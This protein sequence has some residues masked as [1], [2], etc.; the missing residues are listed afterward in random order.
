MI[1]RLKRQGT[2]VKIVDPDLRPLADRLRAAVEAGLVEGI[3]AKP[4][5]ASWLRN[6]DPT[7]KA[8]SDAGGA[9]LILE[10]PTPPQARRLPS[11]LILVPVKNPE[12]KDRSLIGAACDALLRQFNK[13]GENNA[14]VCDFTR[15]W[16]EQS[17]SCTA[18]GETTRLGVDG[19]YLEQ[20]LAGGENQSEDVAFWRELLQKAA[21]EQIAIDDLL[22][23]LLSR[24]TAWF[25]PYTKD[26]LRAEDAL[27]VFTLMQKH[28]QENSV[29][30]HCYG[31]QYWNHPSINA[32]FSGKGGAVTFHDTQE[33]G[34]S[35][36][37][38]D[39]GHIYSWAGRTDPAFET[40]CKRNA[41]PLSRIED[42]FLRSVGLGAGLARGAMLAVDDLGIYYDPSRPSRLEVLLKEYELSPAERQRGE[43][44]I[45]LIIRARVSKYNFGKSQE[46]TYPADR[47]KILVPGQVADDAAIRKSRS[48]TIDCANTPNVNLDLLRLARD[49]HPDAFL[50]FKP[51]PDVET[52][53]RK[54][55]VP[56]ETALQY[57][58]D[59][60]EDANI[61]DLIEA[62]DVIETFSSLSGFEA[63]LRGKKVCVHGAPFY[64]GWGLCEDLTAIEG[65]G[66]NRT[67]PELV[68]LALV[69]YAR[70]ID[71]VSLLPCTPEFLVTR[72]AE[73]RTDKRHLLVNSIKRHSSWLG[74]KLGI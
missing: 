10:G 46:F 68:Y 34:V 56:R 4:F 11:S 38:T 16:R 57:A 43:A 31:A 74:R 23:W 30:A 63:L 70:T 39:G 22:N 21:H 20:I 17:L 35:A 7:G 9:L 44:L 29:P 41:V 47:E 2:M 60:A 66:R 28:W 51:H 33:D 52:G 27:E 45:D 8:T 49:R 18:A 69:K 53:L 13:A 65:R 14:S 5:Q 54:G 71:P 59:I 12:K 26:L 55:R 72:L 61:I 67:L 40:L 3:G 36:A 64:A 15:I 62:V 1:G 48:A 50:V 73:Q 42:G 25:S 19:L 24:R 37:R 6:A 58:D 32:T